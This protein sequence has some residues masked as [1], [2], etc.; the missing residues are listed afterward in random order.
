MGTSQEQETNRG[1]FTGRG[2]KGYK[3]SDER[4]NED[5]CD[6]LCQNGELDA[7]DIECKVKDG[8]VTLTGT[9]SDRNA[10]RMAEDII[11][12]VSGVTEVNN[13]IRVKRE[14][15]GGRQGERSESGQGQNQGAR[16]AART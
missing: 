1:Q 16:S 7:S 14:T 8:E 10:K 5:V 11:E 9:V 13:Q 3:R 6:I 12:N 15:Q 2:P 4:I